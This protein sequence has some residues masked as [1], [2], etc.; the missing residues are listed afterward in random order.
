MYDQYQHL[1]QEE[2]KRACKR[3]SDRIEDQLAEGGWYEALQGLIH[4]LATFPLAIL[5]GPVIETVRKQ[6]WSPDGQPVVVEQQCV[7][8]H[9]VSPFDFYPS[10]HSRTVGDDWICEEI[11]F[12]ATD[13]QLKAQSPGWLGSRLMQIL[14]E[15]ITAQQTPLLIAG[16]QPD[17]LRAQLEI[18]PWQRESYTTVIRGI[19]FW[20]MVPGHMLLNWANYHERTLADIGF[21][22]VQPRQW[23]PIT[24]VLIKDTV[25]RVGPVLD[26]LAEFPYSATS[27]EKR[28]GSLW[29]RALP[30]KMR[31]CQ[32][33]YTATLRNMIDSLALCKGPLM[34]YDLSAI[35]TPVD[36]IQPLQ[37]IAFDT[38]RLHPGQDPV[39]WK[40]PQC[41]AHIFL[42]VARYFEEQADNRT[43]I[44]RYVYGADKGLG[45]AGQTASGLDMM[46]SQSAKGIRRVLGFV[47][48][49]VIRPAL[50]RLVRLNQKFSKDPNLRGDAQ[51]IAHGALHVLTRDTKGVRQQEFLNI[52]ERP[53][54]RRFFPDPGVAH[55]LRGLARKNNLPDDKVVYSDQEL[56]AIA[57]HLAAQAAASAEA[58]VNAQREDQGN[59]WDG[60]AG[61]VRHGA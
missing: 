26:P 15:C 34:G 38:R 21:P 28:T 11:H 10:P 47:D 46:L 30:E 52:I 43:A 60:Q 55:V 12:S 2:A 48:V 37:V 20:G 36:R 54:F 31:D 49:D 9:R 16:Q 61:G 58:A 6:Q 57:Q 18:R 56:S 59:G 13:L 41:F 7:A 35:R 33:A 14:D 4:D 42:D 19:E 17:S 29:G 25:V 8:F 50:R 5:K 23:Y 24:A 22:A 45:P 40:Q 53:A 3:M 1:A 32:D 51:V 39:W 27:F 44:P